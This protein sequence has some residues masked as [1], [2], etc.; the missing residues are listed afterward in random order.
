MLEGHQFQR[1][2][3]ATVLSARLP[4]TGTRSPGQQRCLDPQ[5]TAT[6]IPQCHTGHSSCMRSMGSNWGLDH[7]RLRRWQ[8][9]AAR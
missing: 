2:A 4:Y 9:E 6:A 8:V 5:E 7:L 3:T 1:C